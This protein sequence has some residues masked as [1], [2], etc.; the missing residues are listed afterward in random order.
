MSLKEFQ[1]Q[2]DDG[3]TWHVEQSGS[4]VAPHIICIPS[5][6][7]DC[8]SFHKLAPLLSSAFT[9]I[10]FDMPGFSRSIPAPHAFD[11]LSPYVIANQVIGL[12][13]KLSIPTATIYGS[14]SGGNIALAML[15]EHE[16]HVERIIVH[17]V[18]M[19]VLESMR[20]WAT[21][22]ASEDPK[23]VALCQGVFLNGMNEDKD[24]WIGLGEEYH[25]RLEK[26]YVTWGKNYI[27]VVE[28]TRWE[29]E[30]LKRLAKK[31]N[32]TLGG[33]MQLAW[34]FDN[35]VL[36][37]EVGI[38]IKVLDSKHFPYVSIPEVVAE[39][40]KECCK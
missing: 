18:P 27:P 28:K 2:T 16:K 19:H 23:I 29:K 15:Q 24:A 30:E 7:G 9:V 4:G 35:V 11:N 13:D 21:W 25:K 38:K 22:P 20:D 26:N 8:H 5:G 39:Y 40:I 14:S 31:V 17:E 3:M 37:T 32:W 6:E 33:Q 34:F 12:M 10:T 1:V 36:C